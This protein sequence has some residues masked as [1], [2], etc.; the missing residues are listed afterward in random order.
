MESSNICPYCNQPNNS[1]VSPA[2]LNRPIA[3][4]ETLITQLLEEK[5]TLLRRLNSIQ[6]LTR[7]VPVEIL[8]FI[9]EEASREPPMNLDP[10]EEP[11]APNGIAQALLLGTVSTQWR[12][13]ALSASHIWTNLQYQ[14][15]PIQFK[16]QLSMIEEA[17][18]RSGNLPLMVMFD[19]SKL[20]L[21][22]IRG[23]SGWHLVDPTT[24]EV[25]CWNMERIQSLSLLDPPRPWFET[26]S[27][28]AQ[29][30]EL[31]VKYSEQGAIQP[32][33]LSLI[34]N[35]YLRKLAIAGFSSNHCI[36]LPSSP[37]LTHVTL[38]EVHV[39][40]AISVLLHCPQLITFEGSTL[41]CDGPWY[42][43]IDNAKPI[44]M[45]HLR[46]LTWRG[47]D[48]RSW[49]RPFIQN[50]HLP[51]LQ[52]LC[53]LINRDAAQQDTEYLPS[54]QAFFSRL[55]SLKTL[56]LE[57]CYRTRH[58]QLRFPANMFPQWLEHLT[59]KDWHLS[60]VH[61]LLESEAIA[62]REGGQVNP[63]LPNLRK[64]SIDLGYL[65][66]E[67]GQLMDILNVLKG[68][69]S[70]LVLCLRLHRN[71]DMSEPISMLRDPSLLLEGLE[72]VV[73]GKRVA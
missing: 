34:D 13:A 58:L 4:I 30:T 57:R 35:L 36:R 3:K 33:E 68:R 43:D 56:S 19:F 41:E 51:A 44:V 52:T 11:E 54:L 16:S 15:D 37:S 59:L 29:L 1:P 18:D 67:P 66:F 65:A 42:N 22:L 38:S 45:E 24:D 70:P 6:S 12:Q 8:A 50:L 2:P 9:F 62:G 26:T 71:I 21:P 31:T 17:L 55:S 72:L 23:I 61:E 69:T 27:E 40:M 48:L 25:L 20:K 14:L 10:D 5:H 7:N 60:Y 39:A 64:L 63:L 32:D 49:E 73:N 53:L 46:A 28:L 47:A